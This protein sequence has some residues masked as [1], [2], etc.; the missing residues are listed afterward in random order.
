MKPIEKITSY[1]REDARHIHEDW[2]SHDTRDEGEIYTNDW[3]STVA[4]D[5]SLKGGPGKYGAI[6]SRNSATLLRS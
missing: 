6:G 4:I 2:V 1:V 5:V 3:C